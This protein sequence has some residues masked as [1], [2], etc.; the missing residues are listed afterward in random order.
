LSPVRVS[1]FNRLIAPHVISSR[2]MDGGQPK[3]QLVGPIWLDHH[4]TG[5]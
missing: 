2:Q 1:I 3:Q 4:L 5:G